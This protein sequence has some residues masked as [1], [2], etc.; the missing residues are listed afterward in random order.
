MDFSV[1]LASQMAP[2]GTAILG[3]LGLG[4]SKTVPRSCWFGPV[5]G[6]SF[7]IDF[8]IVLGS[9]W[10]RFWASWVSFWA[11]LGSLGPVLGRLGLVLGHS[12]W[13]DGVL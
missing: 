7:G 8:L 4:V 3:K 9:S 13:H 12:G 1:V 10:G 2:G 5:F 11:I 6:L